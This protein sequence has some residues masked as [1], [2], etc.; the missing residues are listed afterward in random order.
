MRENQD[1]IDLQAD[2]KVFKEIEREL[3]DLRIKSDNFP[4]FPRMSAVQSG[5]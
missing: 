5:T 2:K 1:W 3:S 4:E